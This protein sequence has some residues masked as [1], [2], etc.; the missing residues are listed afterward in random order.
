[1]NE[2]DILRAL[3]NLFK[4]FHDPYSSNARK[5]EIEVQLT[6]IKAEPNFGSFCVYFIE[7][8]PI[9][10][11]FVIHFILQTLETLINLQWSNTDG[12]LKQNI[13][14]IL[15]MNLKSHLSPHLRN[16]YAKLLVEIAKIDW[17]DQYPNFF[18]IVLQML[19]SSNQLTGLILLKT[20][21]EEF[22]GRN[23]T[24]ESLNRKEKIKEL[25]YNYIPIVFDSLHAILRNVEFTQ[26]ALSK[27]ALNTIQIIFVWLPIKNI[28]GELI[29]TICNLM[30]SQHEELRLEVINTINVIFYRKCCLKGTETCFNHIYN[31]VVE[32]L[33]NLVS[34]ID[35]SN[36]FFV[37]KLCELLRLLIEQHFWRFELDPAFSSLDFL[38][39]FFTYTM[40]LSSVECFQHC[41]GVWAV[42]FK[43]IKPNNTEKYLDLF[44]SLGSSL[45]NKIQFSY[46]YQQLM[47]I[48]MVN[49]DQD[50]KSEWQYFLGFTVEIISKVAQFAP[51]QTIN[52]ILGSWNLYNMEYNKCEIYNNSET[53]HLVYILRD[54]ATLTFTLASL[55]HHFYLSEN[56]VLHKTATPIIYSL[57]E[58]T[59]KSASNYRKIKLQIL[60]INNH[61]LTLSF[62][63]VESELLSSLKTWLC[64]METR[65]QQCYNGDIFLSLV[66][67]FL[68]EGDQ[69][70]VKI[71]SAAAQ[72]FL[73]LAK[74][75]NNSC[76]LQNNV[77][78]EFVQQVPEIK[79][80]TSDITNTV[81]SAIC[82]ILLKNLKSVNEETLQRHKLLI[83]L[84]FDELTR[85][86]RNLNHSSPEDTVRAV[87]T[88]TLPALS[89][90]IK[91]CR[92]FNVGA[93]KE[94]INAIKPTL[95][96]ALVLF[97]IYVKYIDVYVIFSKFFMSVLK[98]VQS[99]IGLNYT[100]QA[101]QVFFQVAVSEQQSQSLLGIQQL[102]NIFCAVIKEL[103]DKTLLPDILKVCIEVIYPFISPQANENPDIYSR[104]L[105]LLYRI[106]NFHWRHFYNSQVLMGHSAG[107]TDNEIVPD[108]PKRPEL[109]LAV[110]KVFGE[111]LLMDDIHIFQ[112]SLKVLQELNS[113]KKLYYKALFRSHLLSDLL[114]VL[115]N[116]L[117]QKRHEISNDDIIFA[118][119]SMAEV[120][121]KVFFFTFLPQYIQN[122]D[123]INACNYQ[124][125]MAH[126][127]VNNDQDLP[128][129]MRDLQNFAVDFHHLRKCNT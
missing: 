35:N 33:R 128:S 127:D 6:H 57:I 91:Y 27:E 2:N 87:V 3:E 90:I 75:P 8:G 18:D 1:M 11:D 49:V 56:E 17:P 71:T 79:Y 61:Q 67:P 60:R 21:C 64:W 26:K 9:A 122:L 80:Y 20:L 48:D 69:M 42:F 110:L 55:A 119:Y 36:E 28:P 96:Q 99:Q 129:F 77:V 63:D 118:I 19:K 45:I 114:H 81:N 44:S 47:G 98:N 70:S 72:L 104:F 109:F 38:S 73:E 52:L 65:N 88:N 86:F 84:F 103:T 68:K 54:F 93:K 78:V 29:G 107:C 43:Q 121:F 5:Q 50:N 16:K 53:E 32:W 113:T 7:Q 30:Y 115:L 105:K 95:D 102:L 76:S 89:L 116:T 46:N 108:S 124:A 106:L 126:F 101:M 117:L 100:K 51:L 10:S 120:D 40:Y 125:L 92:S 22:M 111:A 74:R 25:L 97:P 23:A 59:V 66:L 58:D 39:K 37:E 112:Q 85:D 12:H 14:S 41:L 24:Y 83:K 123:D 15:E 82:E 34:K 4:E 94:L 13:K 31:H 62:I